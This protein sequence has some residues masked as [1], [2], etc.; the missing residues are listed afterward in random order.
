LGATCTLV[1]K[2]P[3]LPMLTFTWKVVA[4]KDKQRAKMNFHANHGKN[5]LRNVGSRT[6]KLAERLIVQ[7]RE[8]DQT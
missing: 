6:K 7:V 3:P 8:R 4:H 1:G 5:L 2:K